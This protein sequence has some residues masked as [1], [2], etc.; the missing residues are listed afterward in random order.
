MPFEKI[1]ILNLEG[2][3]IQSLINENTLISIENSGIYFVRIYTDKGIF[4]EKLL[5]E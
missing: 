3:I 2:R 5:V 1:E 4:T